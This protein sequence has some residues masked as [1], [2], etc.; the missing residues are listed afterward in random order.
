MYPSYGSF[1][2]SV[3]RPL[4]FCAAGPGPAGCAHTLPAG[5]VADA[6]VTAATGP[7]TSFPIET[8]WARCH[9]RDKQYGYLP[10]NLADQKWEFQ[11]QRDKDV[12]SAPV[13]S[14]P[15]FIA[16]HRV[17]SGTCHSLRLQDGPTQPARQKQTPLTCRMS[18]RSPPPSALR[19]SLR[20]NET[21]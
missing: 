11:G 10:V 14:G 16:L 1:L 21:L 15:S 19:H 6:I 3:L 13:P 7:V 4:T 20:Q 2:T 12:L 18:R 8:G 17:M 5:R 9:E